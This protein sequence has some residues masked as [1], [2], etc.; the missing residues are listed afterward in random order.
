[1]AIFA[2]NIA[3]M[4]K[5]LSDIASFIRKYVFTHISLLLIIGFT[6]AHLFLIDHNY[7]ELYKNDRRIRSLQNNIAKE[8]SLIQEYRNKLQELG[9][10]PQSIKHIAREQYGMQRVHED[11]FRVVTDTATTQETVK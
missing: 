10:D 11:V 6:V 1:M 4:K 5:I 9:N 7:M 2:G 8:K 3:V